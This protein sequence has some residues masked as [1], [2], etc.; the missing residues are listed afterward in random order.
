MK[1]FLISIFPI[2]VLLFVLLWISWGLKCVLVFFGAVLFTIASA[3]GF[4]KWVEFVDK[5]IKD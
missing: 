2:C 1:K 4:V 5:H 3:F